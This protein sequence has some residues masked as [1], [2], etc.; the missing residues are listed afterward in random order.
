[1]RICGHEGSYINKRSRYELYL[2][3]A[4]EPSVIPGHQKGHDSRASPS[5]VEHA[6]VYIGLIA[7]GGDFIRTGGGKTICV[8]LT[9]D[10]QAQKHRNSSVLLRRCIC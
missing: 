8:Y 1:M 7:A 9:I 3:V 5:H 6:I 2:T 4:H 10:H